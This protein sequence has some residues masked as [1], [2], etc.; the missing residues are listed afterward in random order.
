[1]GHHILLLE[2]A[3]THAHTTQSSSSLRTRMV[4]KSHAEIYVIV[5]ELKCL[6]KISDVRGG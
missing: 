1:M 5:N 4:Q 3:N 2:G 6:T